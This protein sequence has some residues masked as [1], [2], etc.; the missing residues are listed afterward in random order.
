MPCMHYDILV[1]EIFEI[2]VMYTNYPRGCYKITKFFEFFIENSK[3][4][5]LS[6]W[7]KNKNSK[8][9]PENPVFNPGY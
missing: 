3:N 6:M 2:K 1:I 4:L 5:L 8:N 7:H 9:I